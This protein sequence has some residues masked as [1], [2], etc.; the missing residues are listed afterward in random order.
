[1]TDE[2]TKTISQS[3]RPDYSQK[4]IPQSRADTISSTHPA[5]IGKSRIDETLRNCLT[6]WVSEQV[7]L[8]LLGACSM[9]RKP[10]GAL[11]HRPFPP[12]TTAHCPP[13]RPPPTIP[14][15]TQENCR[16]V[17]AL[18]MHS[19]VKPYSHHAYTATPTAHDSQLQFPGSLLQA[20]TAGRC[21]VAMNVQ[22]IT[23][24]SR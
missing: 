15:G 17:A 9:G 14:H 20:A 16:A 10:S 22:P 18:S 6:V 7:G 5:A 3:S 2:L 12:P 13:T 1:M 8:R 4:P 23:A 24:H 11:S 21:P 19:H